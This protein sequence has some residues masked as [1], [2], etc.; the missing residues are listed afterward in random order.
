MPLAVRPA[1]LSGAAAVLAAMALFAAPAP[2]AE[3]VASSGCPLNPVAQ[4]FAA[5]QDGSDYFLAPDGDFENDTSSW[6]LGDGA[7]VV[8]GNEPFYVGS[9]DDDMSLALPAGST[10]A[11]A[12]IC[13]ADVHRTMRFFAKGAAGG[14]L[15]V[16]ARFYGRDADLGR[17]RLGAVD[18]SGDWAA[19][20]ALPMRVN[21]AA[22][23]F[24]DALSVSLQFTPREGD[25]QIDDVY[26]DPFRTK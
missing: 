13:I 21:E 1:A 5:W 22:A 3:T 11:T 6:S 4:T 7:Q 10:A 18:G 16:N 25:W 8:E 19:T 17:V 15:V 26:V 14:R 20:A 23:G 24:D 12:T 2:A 9:P